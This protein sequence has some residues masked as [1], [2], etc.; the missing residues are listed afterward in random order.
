[1]TS[2]ASQLA[3]EMEHEYSQLAVDMEHEYSLCKS[4]KDQRNGIKVCGVQLSVTIITDISS[5]RSKKWNMNTHFAN[6]KSAIFNREFSL[7]STRRMF[8]LQ[9][10]RI[11]NQIKIQLLI[12]KYS[13][14]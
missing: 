14:S 1:M 6:P 12:M 11:H 4:K 3:V 9:N 10:H 8:C 5:K 7:F 13:Y 2:E